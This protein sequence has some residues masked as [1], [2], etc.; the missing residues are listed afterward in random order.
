MGRTA[1]RT[2]PARLEQERLVVHEPNHG[3]RVRMVTEAEALKI[4]QAL[5][6]REAALH[7][8]PMFP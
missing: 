7:G 6:A 8:T 2:L 3:A 1:V 5:T 4:T